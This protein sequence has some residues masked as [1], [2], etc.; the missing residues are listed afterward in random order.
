MN[1]TE[2]VS[3]PIKF[4][5]SETKLDL[6]N[7]L[8]K[9]DVI[10]SKLSSI[11]CQNVLRQDWQESFDSIRSK[12]QNGS[13]S[14]MND[15]KLSLAVLIFNASIFV[16]TEKTDTRCMLLELFDDIVMKL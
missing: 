1:F 13:Y 11:S 10:N 12:I 9:I 3:P 14:T 4:E 6:E 5:N 7:L 15:I 2:I 8:Y 16:S